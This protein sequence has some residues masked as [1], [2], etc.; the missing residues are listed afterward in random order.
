[1]K[2]D[3]VVDAFVSCS[4]P[5]FNVCNYVSPMSHLVLRFVMA[6]S[7]LD[8]NV[9]VLPFVCLLNTFNAFLKSSVQMHS[10]RPAAVIC[11]Y[12]KLNVFSRL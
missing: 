9:D 3:I 8:F 5:Y 4:F 2:T 12:K 1:L 11:C 7:Q 10:C 6:E